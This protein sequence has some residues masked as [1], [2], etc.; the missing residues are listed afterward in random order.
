MMSLQSKY[1]NIALCG[2]FLVVSHCTLLL[3]RSENIKC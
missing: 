1:V 3:E 2:A